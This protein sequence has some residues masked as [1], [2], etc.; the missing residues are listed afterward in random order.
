[1]THHP[2]ELKR[3]CFVLGKSLLVIK[4]QPQPP[5]LFVLWHLSGKGYGCERQTA[6]FCSGLFWSPSLSQHKQREE[7]TSTA[8]T[9]YPC[10]KKATDLPNFKHLPLLVTAMPETGLFFLISIETLSHASFLTR[11][12]IAANI[13]KQ[14]I[15]AGLIFLIRAILVLNTQSPI[16]SEGIKKKCLL[17]YLQAQRIQAIILPF[18]FIVHYNG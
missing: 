2:F 10:K 15:L 17:S 3:M 9:K 14:A 12:Q 13:D 8:G 6:L 18:L 5:G 4:E 11:A 16:I 1:M 7:S